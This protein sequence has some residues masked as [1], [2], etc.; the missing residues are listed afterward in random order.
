[1]MYMSML[2]VCVERVWYGSVEMEMGGWYG[3][4]LQ[5]SSH[6]ET[7]FHRNRGEHGLCCLY[8]HCPPLLSTTILI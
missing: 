8:V 5:G 2:I 1:M 3:T 7:H 4:R 6:V